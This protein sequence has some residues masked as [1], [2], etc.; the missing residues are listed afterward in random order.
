MAAVLTITD[1]TNS[2]SL[3]TAK[4]AFQLRV[5]GWNVADPPQSQIRRQS[6]YGE[7]SGLIHT[8]PGNV[9]DEFTVLLK[10]SSHDNFA[11]TMQTLL[12]LQREAREHHTTI[13][14]K[15]PVYLQVQTKTETNARFF[16]I[17]DI[18]I[19]HN[20]SLFDR[21]FENRSLLPS[22]TITVERDPYGQ[23]YAPMSSTLVAL[24]QITISAPQA[25][26]TQADTGSQYIA[27]FRDAYALTH[28]YNF[29]D[30]AGTFSSNLIASSSFSYFP[31][32]P[33][34]NDIVYIGSSQGVWRQAVLNIGSAGT[35]NAGITPEIWTGAAWVSTANYISTDTLV[36]QSGSC[37]TG[38][39]V[40][41]VDSVVGWAPTTINGVSAY[42]IRFRISSFTSWSSSPTQTGQV[43]YNPRDAYISV[44]DTAQIKGDVNALAMLRYFKR[45]RTSGGLDFMALG[46]K[47]R[48]LTSFMSRYN[49]GAGNPA[50]WTITN[51]SDTT[52]VTD[53]QS[54][55]GSRASCTFAGTTAA[56]ERV[57]VSTATNQNI[58]DLEGRYHAYLRC[59]QVGGA[60]GAV[61]V[62]L[63]QTYTLITDGPAVSPQ[64]VGGGIEILDMG[65]ITI[66]PSQIINADTGNL[67]FRL[68]IIAS[69]TSSTPDLYIYDLALI[70]ID[71]VAL[72][73]QITDSTMELLERSAGLDIDGGL[74][75]PGSALYRAGTDAAPA[76]TVIGEWEHRGLPFVLPPDKAFQIHFIL[77]SQ[78]SGIYYAREYL[79]GSFQVHALRRWVFM[80]GAE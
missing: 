15:T 8:E 20:N 6:A 58:I 28:V 21:T 1:G 55:G 47:S 46:V 10:G 9:F 52:T 64:A 80:R 61:S 12:T 62:Y 63:R 59:Q 41:T 70:P 35:F 54:P 43:I 39:H 56:A 44:T 40:V 75:R 5:G 32:S 22:I 78:I 69:A 19:Q 3:L 74:I 67:D 60:V 53:I 13:W 34:A 36:L 77:A 57:R 27:N 4:T 31:A 79:G 73:T 76:S 65:R 11:A 16:T 72:V 2:V 18:R 24:A 48:G 45:V 37:P 66:L 14:Q 23:A 42:W 7:G 68:S 71:E 33:A 50:A 49:F 29:D 17:F 51:G 26:G 30:S 25:P 38:T